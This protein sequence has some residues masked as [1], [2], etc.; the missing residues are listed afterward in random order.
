M[1]KT[2]GKSK[3]FSSSMMNLL[4]NGLL[5]V[6]L[7]LLLI[8]LFQLMTCGK[9]GFDHLS[10]KDQST[11]DDSMMNSIDDLTSDMVYPEIV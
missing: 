11:M 1:A 8:M 7:L 10:D 4:T 5:F 6:G 2:S 3:L 9:E